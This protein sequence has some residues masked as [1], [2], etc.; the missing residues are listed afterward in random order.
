MQQQIGVQHR[1]QTD[2]FKQIYGKDGGMESVPGNVSP[3]VRHWMVSTGAQ[4][5]PRLNLAWDNLICSHRY[6]RR[7]GE[8][9]SGKISRMRGSGSDGS[10]WLHLRLVSMSA[11]GQAAKRSISEPCSKVTAP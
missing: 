8:K 4:S 6:G 10:N 9:Q 3:S 2:R 1:E 11:L 5:L 7:T